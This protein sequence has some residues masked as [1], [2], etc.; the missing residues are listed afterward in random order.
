M[1]PVLLDGECLTLDDLEQVARHGAAVALDPAALPKVQAARRVIE[2]ALAAE[3]PIYGV[4]TGFGPLSDVFVGSADR[5]ALQR[6]LLRS[7]AIGIGDPIGEAETRATILLRANVLAKGHSGVR[8][9]IIE[10]L[11]ELLSR[12]VHP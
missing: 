9:E 7:H 4:S 3:R 12:G 6:N 8:P 5:E 2:A 10:L 1:P 11:C